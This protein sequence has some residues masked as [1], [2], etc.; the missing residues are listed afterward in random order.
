MICQTCHG[1][2]TVMRDALPAVGVMPG[3]PERPP[4][5][6]SI[7]EPCPNCLGTGQDYC[8][9]GERECPG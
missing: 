7:L 3:D 8:C 4:P 1:T 5:S 9:S 2:G 6:F